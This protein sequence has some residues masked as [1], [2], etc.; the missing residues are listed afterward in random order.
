MDYDIIVIGS[1][2]GGYHAAIRAAQLGQRVACVEKE[3][4]GGVCLNTGCIPTKALLH[5]AHEILGA[6][7]AKALGVDF[8]EPRVDLTRVATWKD[9]V[10]KRMTQGVGMLL[11]GNRVDHIEGE[12]IFAGPNLLKVG[13]RDI[14]AEKFI[15]ATG[16]RPISVPGFEVDGDQIVDSSG[17]LLISTIPDRFLAIGGSA[18]GLEFSDIYAALGSEVTV[19]ELLETINPLGDKEVSRELHK[20]FKGRGIQIRTSTKALGCNKTDGGLAVELQQEGSDIETII[21]DKILVAVGRQ[22]NGDLLNL[23]S[24]GVQVDEKGYVP[25][26]SHLQTSEPYVYAIG[27]VA[28]PP[29]LAHKAMKEGLVA[30]EHASGLPAAYDT[31]VPN[32]IYTQPEIASVGMTEEEATVAG[33]S[34]K[35]GRFPLAASGRAS[36]TGNNEGLI[37]LVGDQET[38]ALLG[39]H[40]VG[41]NA[42]ELVSEAVLAIEMGATLE[43]IALSQHAHPTLAEGIMEA[44]EQAHGRAIHTTNRRN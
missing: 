43:D 21:V 32:V 27:D 40:M 30:A 44:A 14:T 15:I 16:S 18:I 39:F 22:P 28:R 4:L 29:L 11:K 5:I 36:T 42:G 6:R 12:A 2:P 24:I 10:V 26:N 41:A 34:V 37:K 20:S 38:D 23:A 3:S 33:Y 19:V 9:E 1:G 17:A 31:I 35:T 25:V 13:D 7:H 8:G